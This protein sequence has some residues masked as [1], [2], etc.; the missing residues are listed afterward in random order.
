M[1]EDGKRDVCIYEILV[2]HKKK[3]ILPVLITWMDLEGT[4]LCEIT[5]RKTILCNLTT[6]GSHLYGESKKTWP[7]GERAQAAGMGQQRR[8]DAGDQAEGFGSVFLRAS[9]EWFPTWSL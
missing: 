6:I 1:N 2:G 7:E 8:E 9:A 3:E 4:V 5:Q